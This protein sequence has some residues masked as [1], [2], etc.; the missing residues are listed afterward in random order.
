VQAQCPGT[1]PGP[2]SPAFAFTSG[3]ALLIGSKQPQP[4]CH[5]PELPNGG[6]VRLA[7]VTKNGAAFSG[8]LPVRVTLKSTFATDTNNG[9]CELQNLQI[10]LE[11]LLGDLTCRAGKCKGVLHGL[12]CLP[13]SCADTLLTTEFVS[14]VV[15]D[16]AGTAARDAGHLRHAGARRRE[17]TLEPDR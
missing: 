2:C 9:N 7:G 15:Q 3:T 16:D 11:S 4:V 17:L 1:P 10:Q 5:E 13:G 14:L 8:T 6:Q 12:A